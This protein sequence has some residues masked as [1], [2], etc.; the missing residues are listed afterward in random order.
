MTDL[1]FIIMAI[2]IFALVAYLQFIYLKYIEF[3]SHEE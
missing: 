2:H 3:K 1:I